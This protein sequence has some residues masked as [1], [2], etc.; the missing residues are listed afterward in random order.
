M[1]RYV[2]EFLGTFLI[3]LAVSLTENPMTIG[4][5]YMVM[6][7]LGARISGAHYNPA[8]TQA[9]WLRGAFNTHFIPHYVIAQFLGAL[10]ALYFVY[11]LAGLLYVPDISPEDNVLLVCVMETL[12]TLSLC[13]VYLATRTT[14]QFK[15]TQLYGLILGFSL[16]GLSSMG[17]LF[18]P[19]IGCAAFVLHAFL[20][21][22]VMHI[23]NK[24]LVYV[25]CPLVG[26][27][28]AG[29]AFDYLEAP[30]SGEFVSVDS[31]N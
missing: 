22:S 14:H 4:F 20:A 24:L 5:I 30:A 7:Y 19:A 3:V 17:G 6:L 18:N 2:V 10:A 13:Y 9:L 25:I 12:F 28:L 1:K 27:A 29:L 15:G 26:S 31:V 21:G 23:G 16:I 8:V 11:A